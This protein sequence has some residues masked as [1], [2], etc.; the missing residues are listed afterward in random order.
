MYPIILRPSRNKIKF[1]LY[2]ASTSTSTNDDEQKTII[3][4]T[5]I[6]NMYIK[7]AIDKLFSTNF[8][9]TVCIQANSCN[10]VINTKTKSFREV[11]FINDVKYTIIRHANTFHQTDD[12][13]RIPLYN[14]LTGLINK[15][16]NTKV[17]HILFL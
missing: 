13:I 10:T 14:C 9:G 15:N 16:N 2:S 11:I 4:V 6:V 8:N 17:K 12:N 1:T 3:D 7:K 5:N